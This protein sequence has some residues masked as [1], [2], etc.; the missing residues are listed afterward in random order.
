MVIQRLQLEGFTPG[1]STKEPHLLAASK[2]NITPNPANEY[3]NL[4][5]KLDAVNPAVYVSILDGKG[6]NIVGSK[7]EKNIQNGVMTMDVHSLPS[8]VYYLW[9]RTSE[10][11]TLK[12]FVV[13]H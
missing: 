3:V 6:R 5:L 2:F 10:G 12:Q 7:S 4:E 13:T 11:T 8:G 9:V 1:V